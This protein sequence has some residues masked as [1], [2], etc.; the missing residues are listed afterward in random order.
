MQYDAENESGMIVLHEF[1][2]M[3]REL[4]W[5]TTR[6]QYNDGMHVFRSKDGRD[7]PSFLRTGNGY[8]G[9]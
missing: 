8:S 1:P 6:M 9:G 2:Q 5:M 7:R 3:N 4:P